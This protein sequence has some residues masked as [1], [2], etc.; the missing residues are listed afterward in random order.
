MIERQIC[1]QKTRDSTSRE[2]QY[3]LTSFDPDDAQ[4]AI[5]QKDAIKASLGDQLLLR[6]GGRLFGYPTGRFALHGITLV[7][8]VGR[9]RYTFIDLS[10][11]DKCQSF[12]SN[13]HQ[14][15]SSH[16]SHRI[17]EVIFV[18]RTKQSTFTLDSEGILRF[19]DRTDEASRTKAEFMVKEGISKVL[20]S[21]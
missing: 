16:R 3:M 2:I 14:E 10:T 18:D 4:R 15:D 1:Y 5:S 11:Y 20:T 17:E 21:E 7:N 9:P 6:L 19:H 12:Y 8:N 13:W